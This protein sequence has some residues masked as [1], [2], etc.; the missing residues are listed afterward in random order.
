MKLKLHILFVLAALLFSVQKVHAC[1]GLPLVNL[2]FTIPSD[3]TSVTISGESDAA[4]NGCN[5]NGGYS[6]QVQLVCAGISFTGAVTHTSGN[7]FKPDAIQMP[8]PD[9]VIDFSSLCPGTVYKLQ[10]REYISEGTSSEGPWSATFTF[11]TPGVQP[12]LFLN[13]TANP[14]NICPGQY[15]ILT[16]S[17]SGGCGNFTYQWNSGLGS[18][19]VKSVNPI[20]TT[21]YRAEV[22]DLCT[23]TIIAKDVVVTVGGAAIAGTASTATPI[24]C[25]GNSATINL[26]GNNGTTIQWQTSING[27]STWTNSTGDTLSS[28]VTGP[29]NATTW[30]RARVTF[31]GNTANS[32]SVLI[33]VYQTPTVTVFQDTTICAGGTA[34]LQANPSST[35]GTYLWS[36][37]AVTQSIS[38]SPATSTTYSVVYTLQNCPS[39]PASATVAVNYA[40]TVTLNDYFI[41]PGE[42]ATIMANVS[43]PGGTYAW[44]TGETT[45]TITVSPDSTKNYFLIYTFDGCPSLADTST[46]TVKPVPTISVNDITICEGFSGTLNAVTNLAGGSYEWSPNGQISSSISVNPLSSE[47][48]SVV[49]TLNGCSNNDTALVTVIQQPEISLSDTSLC[50]GSSVLLVPVVSAAGGTY[51]WSTGASSST[52]LVSPLADSTF[53]LFYSFSGCISEMASALVLVKPTPVLTVN[54]DT[55]CLGDSATLYANSSLIGGTFLWTPGNFTTDFITVSPDNTTEYTVSQTVNNCTSSAIGTVKVNTIPGISAG[56]DVSICNGASAILTASGADTYLWFPGGETTQSITVSPLDTSEFIVTGFINGCA[57]RDSIIVNVASPLVILA[58]SSHST[59]FNSNNGTIEVIASGSLPPYTYSWNSGQYTQAQEDSI[60]AGSYTVIV[61]DFLNCSDSATVVV[62]QPALLSASAAQIN[63]SCNGGNTGE[64]TV[65]NVN[66]GTLPYLYSWNGAAPQSNNVLT[67][68]GAGNH[69]VIITDANGCSALINYVITQPDQVSFTPSSN[70]TICQGQSTVLSVNTAGGTPGYEFN[71]NNNGFVTGSSYT[72]SP[73]VTTSYSV[74]IRDSRNCTSAIHNFI[75][76]V[77]N[78]LNVTITPSTSSICLGESTT[79]TANPSGGNITGYTFLWTPGNFTSQSISVSPSDTLIYQ[80]EL[81]DGCTNQSDLAQA[82]V[83]VKPLPT[84]G[85]STDINGVCPVACIKFIDNSTSGNSAINSWTWNI[86]T[87]QIQN[88]QNFTFCYENSGSYDISLLVTNDLGCSAQ[89]T[90]PGFIT[91]HPKPKASFIANKYVA[92]S[93]NPLIVFT[94]NSFGSTNWAWN[95]GDGNIQ[96]GLQNPSNIYSEIGEFP[97]TLIITNDFGCT[98][99]VTD[100]ITIIQAMGVYI[101]NAFTPDGDGANDIFIAQGIG[102]EEDKFEMN[103]FNRWGEMIFTSTDL[104]K[105]WDGIGK[106]GKQAISGVYVYKITLKT[107]TGEI[108]TYKGHVTLIR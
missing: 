15:S 3:S 46:V 20:I 58:T 75:V 38:V 93:D 26:A 70:P 106:H 59:C 56:P 79:L 11:K 22:T 48:Y 18:G 55:I 24:I 104:H 87:G 60:S 66:G 4:T 67:G 13:V 105:G 44:S 65:N 27:G 50:S 96:T 37:G 7:I 61:S 95:F 6:M 32:N 29:L 12:P 47:L 99:S 73:V 97:V 36:N 2:T 82:V 57:G 49:Y 31:C 35:G 52:L 16:A 34:Q 92:N 107:N 19:P 62:D 78:P 40:P 28:F 42:N 39:Q 41:C 10:V 81:N 23:G 53:S 76:S 98:D 33:V 91:I 30:F 85:F 9:L 54:N 84:V 108:L 64:A 14:A 43:D 101:P 45:A 94:D 51:N 74:I 103:I 68:I 88:Q 100:Y 71:W 1:H 90:M 102:I 8:Y 5:D 86:G 80:V 89:L 83:N 25:S 17:G 77:A 21:T 72:V 63:V 69:S